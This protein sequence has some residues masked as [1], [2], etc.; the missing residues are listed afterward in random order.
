MR[1]D[2]KLSIIVPIFNEATQIRRNLDLLL[3]QVSEYF[4][5]FEIIA[6]S[7]G[8]TDGTNLKLLSFRHSDVKPVILESNSGKGGAVRAGFQAATG[9]YVLFI[10]GGM[11]IHP[12]EIRIFMGLM[13]LYECDI[14]IGS[15]RHPQSKVEYPWYR[16]VLSIIFQRFV[17]AL[18]HINVTD[19][20]VGIKLFRRAV[21]DAILPQLQIDRYGFDLELLSL[22]KLH[23]FGY[24]LEAPIQIDYFQK[25]DKPVWRE[26]GHVIRVGFS[27]LI[28]T[29]RLYNRLKKMK[30]AETTSVEHHK[31]AS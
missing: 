30:I 27:L 31:R 17:R 15:K 16:Q 26:I 1:K 21:I 22:A 3:E 14:V 28:D 24:M 5:S 2:S 19:T 9:D 4:P 6:V 8:S 29:L 18:F 10:D 13:D 12:K 20:Q 11:E 23:G 7:D 25:N